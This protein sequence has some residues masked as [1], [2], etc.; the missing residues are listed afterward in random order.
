MHEPIIFALMVLLSLVRLPLG[1]DAPSLTMVLTLAVLA[2][3]LIVEFAIGLALGADFALLLWAADR[4]ADLGTSPALAVF[5]AAFV[6]GW[7]VQLI[8]HR[9]EGNRP[10]LLTSLFQVVV[11]PVYLMAELFFAGAQEGPGARDR[12]PD[13]PPYRLTGRIALVRPVAQCPEDTRIVIKHIIPVE[14]VGLRPCQ[15][16][17]APRV[18]PSRLKAPGPGAMIDPAPR[19]RPFA[20]IG[21][22]SP[23]TQA[24]NWKFHR[25]PLK[26]GR[27]RVQSNQVSAS[28]SRC[29]NS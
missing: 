18:T 5:A 15:P 17:D 13:R 29:R 10:A 26:P 7:V 28:R 25:T 24:A 2:Y 27:V 20:S 23:D 8:G 9:A 21:N 12:R 22:P 14:P 6:G 11:S 4:I 3:Y 1:D 16:L 19:R